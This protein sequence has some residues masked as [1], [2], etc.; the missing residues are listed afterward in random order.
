MLIGAPL[1]VARACTCCVIACSPSEDSS[2]F[3]RLP[4]FARRT[5]ATSRCADAHSLL[6]FMT[7][8]ID[9]QPQAPSLL[10]A[11]QPLAGRTYALRR[12]ADL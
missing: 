2:I 1:L 12:F 8:M 4:L 5:P 10:G 6:I 11:V 7:S 9:G 3:R